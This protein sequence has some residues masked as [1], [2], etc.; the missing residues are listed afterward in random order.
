MKNFCPTA[1]DGSVKELLKSRGEGISACATNA[2]ADHFDFAGEV[3]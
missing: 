1:V 3:R 2:T